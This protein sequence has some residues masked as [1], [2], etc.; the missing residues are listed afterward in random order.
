DPATGLWDV[1]T[2]AVGSPVTLAIRATVV[3]PDPQTN[4]ATITHADQFD[5]NPANNNATAP[6][7]PQ[8]ADL[9]LTK[10]VDNASPNVRDTIPFTV[11]IQNLGPDAATDVLISDPLPAGLTLVSDAP[12][13]GSYDAASGVWTVGSVSVGTPQSLQI[14]VVVASASAV[15]NTAA[16]TH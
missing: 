7:T 15:T 5:P 16:I 14:T 2:V 8:Q 1:G 10:Q 11:G 3:S 9:V 4:T 6:D 13:Q 12:S